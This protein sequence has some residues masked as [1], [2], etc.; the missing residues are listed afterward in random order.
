MGNDDWFD[1]VQNQRLNWLRGRSVNTEKAEESTGFLRSLFVYRGSIHE[2]RKGGC[3]ALIKKRAD[4][5][6]VRGFARRLPVAD[7]GRVE[8]I[9]SAQSPAH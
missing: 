9:S 7:D 3:N 6:D 8:S 5:G 2:R 1:H 4:S